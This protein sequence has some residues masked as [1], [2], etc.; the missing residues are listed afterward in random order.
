[1]ACSDAM[2]ASTSGSVHLFGHASCAVRR[3]V[4]RNL[5][6]GCKPINREEAVTVGAGVLDPGELGVDLGRVAL[7]AVGI[8]DPFVGGR[9][10]V[11][12][13]KFAHSG[14]MV[15]VGVSVDRQQHL[16]VSCVQQSLHVGHA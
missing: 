7:V 12:I 2:C 11:Q 5:P 10:D 13:G 9:V 4:S 16:V 1:M 6:F 15:N 8:A 14:N 3:K